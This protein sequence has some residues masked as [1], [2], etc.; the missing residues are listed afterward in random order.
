MAVMAGG[1]DRYYPAGNEELLRAI[2]SRGIL[3]A[4]VPPGAAP[5]RWRFLQRN[6]LIA[7]LA[8]ATIVVEARW[9]SGALN[10]AH[11]AAGLGRGVGAVP[12]SVYSANSAGTHRLLRDGSAIAVTDAAEAAEL[13]GPLGTGQAGGQEV[14]A[15]HDGLGVDDL[16]LLDALPVRRGSTVDKLATVAGIPVRTVLA[17]LGRLEAA[18]L[19]VQ[20]ATG[21][22]RGRRD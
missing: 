8:A 22:R 15:D 17:G 1:L 11:H 2:A 3:L 7:A 12:G 13:A 18:G 19:A 16:L 14:L 20:D 5:T 4:E 6:R 21:W 10:T 9:R